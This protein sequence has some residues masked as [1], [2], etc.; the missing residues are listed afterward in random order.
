MVAVAVHCV[1][2]DQACCLHEGVADVGPTKLMPAG[3]AAPAKKRQIP[4]KLRAQPIRVFASGKLC[5]AVGAMP[6]LLVTRVSY[7]HVV[8]AKRFVRVSKL[9]IER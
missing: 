5:P 2:V 1:V 3:Q 4:T 9:F 6:T 8:Y 7:G